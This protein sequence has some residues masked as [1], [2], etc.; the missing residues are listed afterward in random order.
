MLTVPLVSVEEFPAFSTV[1]VFEKQSVPR[2]GKPKK[3]TQYTTRGSALAE[4][5]LFS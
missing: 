2:V 5:N 4:D 1:T 3:E